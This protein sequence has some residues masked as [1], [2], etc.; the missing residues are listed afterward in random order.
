M[1]IYVLQTRK[2]DFK[3]NPRSYN[4]LRRDWMLDWNNVKI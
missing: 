3:L 2:L 4:I 1:R